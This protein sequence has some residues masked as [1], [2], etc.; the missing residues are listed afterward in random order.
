MS[1]KKKDSGKYFAGALMLIALMV[2]AIVLGW[3]GLE[4]AKESLTNTST[5][6]STP[7]PPILNTTSIP[8]ATVTASNNTVTNSSTTNQTSVS[9]TT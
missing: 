7:I 2:I 1:S 6:P 4:I 5:L 9:A 8:N 3:Y